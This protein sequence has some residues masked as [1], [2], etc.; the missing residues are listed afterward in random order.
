MKYT[1]SPVGKQFRDI[2]QL[3]G[4]EKTIATLAL[5]FALHRFRR[6]PFFIMDEVDDALDNANVERVAQFVQ[7]TSAQTQCII[8]SH[9]DLLFERSDSLVGVYHNWKEASSAILTIDLRKYDSA[10]EHV[11]SC[12]VCSI[13][14][15][16]RLSRRV[17]LEKMYNGK[18]GYSFLLTGCI[19]Q[20]IF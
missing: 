8:I 11:E 5:L 4:G 17:F 20:T 6:A 19:F 2:S 3:S 12:F 15:M 9:K 18:K 1:V 14:H 7:E 16:I 13:L 10:E